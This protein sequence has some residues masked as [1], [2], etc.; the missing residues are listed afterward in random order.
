MNIRDDVS[1]VAEL[2]LTLVEAL[3]DELAT[4]VVENPQDAVVRRFTVCGLV[5]LTQHAR[6]AVEEFRLGRPY[7]ALA[8]DR[9]TFE[10]MIRVIHWNTDQAN[11]MDE[12]RALPIWAARE[13]HRRAGSMEAAPPGVQR[14][15][16]RFLDANSDLEKIR[17]SRFA[18]IAPEIWRYA[19]ELDAEQVRSDLY[20]HV[21]VPSV[22]VHC[23]PLIAEDIID[24]TDP[25]ALV[26]R[27]HSPSA[28]PN[29][30]VL[31]LVRLLVLTARFLAK[32]F[33]CSVDP[34]DRV[35]NKWLN[36]VAE[37]ERLLEVN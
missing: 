23:R 33:K 19:N 15:L 9:C 36:V 10:A 29:A 32:R 18:D 16:R 1:E 12:W 20:T 17:Q 31:E 24:A 8:L 2:G 7:S 21:D 5:V 11:A 37:H 4:P 30:R 28:E 34:I 13:E 26:I 35:C 14:D 27:S 3:L 6:G 25:V 22:F